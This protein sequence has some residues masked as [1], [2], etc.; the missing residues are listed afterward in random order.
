M[1]SADVRNGVTAALVTGASSGLGISFATELAKRG[2]NL[3]L[4]ARRKEPMC[5]LAARL[6]RDYGIKVIVEPLDLGADDSA[7]ILAKRLDAV[8]VEVDVLVNNAAFAVSGL[9]LKQDL[10]HL[11]AMLQLDVLAVT[12]LTHVFGQRMAQRGRGHILLVAS[13]GAYTPSPFAAAYSAAK[14]YVLSLGVAL[15]KEMAPIVGVTVMSPGLMETEFHQVAD[16][17]INP[18]MRR[19]ILPTD[20]VA[21]IG[22]D[23]M[24]AGRAD[25]VAGW[26]NA[27]GAFMSRL[28]PRST[29]A[30]MTYN[31]S[32]P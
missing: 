16:Y 25:V 5:E 31:M 20:R 2:H 30:H 26:I 14:S 12:N 22:L 6:E 8:G 23:A 9:F 28:L 13:V 1:T 24:F 19:S 3:V 18:A 10:S 15:R 17:A 29:L 7:Q 21:K 27:I 11:N 32:K 4:V